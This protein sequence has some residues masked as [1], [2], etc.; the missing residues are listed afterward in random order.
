MERA[1]VKEKI[2]HTEKGLNQLVHKYMD[3]KGLEFSGG[4][5]QKLAIARALYKDAPFYILDEPTAS[6]DAL[7]EK[8]IYEKFEKITDN[9]TTVFISHRLAS[10]KFCD[11]IVLLGTGWRFGA[12]NT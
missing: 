11:R 6:L 2:S 12:G 5:I 10:T 3:E 4:E 8:E 7:A 1:G 9:K